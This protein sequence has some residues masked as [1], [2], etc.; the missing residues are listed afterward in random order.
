MDSTAKELFTA[1]DI[2]QYLLDNP[3]FFVGR[4][5]L[6]DSMS[7]PHHREGTV[8]LFELKLGRQREQIQALEKQK[9]ELMTLASRNDRIF[10]HFMQLEKRI[11]LAKSGEQVISAL[12]K[13]AQQ[14][15]LTVVVGVVGHVS[16]Q[17]QIN[18][19][20]WSKFKTQNLAERGAYLGRLKR[21]D[22]ELIFTQGTPVSELGSYAVLSFEHPSLEGFLCFCSEDG[23]RYQPSQD[24]LYLSHL[25]MVVAQQ[26]TNLQWQ[27]VQTLHVQP[28]S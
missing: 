13:K 16:S 23:G 1:L 9:N 5:H 25:A 7:V 28:H 17:L 18:P 22:R 15:E 27:K 8:S 6:I 3:D 24:T 12:E 14:L 26:L 10:R 19:Q 4:E 11:L 20:D 21:S 2:E